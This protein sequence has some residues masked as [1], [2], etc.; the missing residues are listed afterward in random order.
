MN[1]GYPTWC[2]DGTALFVH[3]RQ[4]NTLFVVETSN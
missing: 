1:G 3:D 4:D 2:A